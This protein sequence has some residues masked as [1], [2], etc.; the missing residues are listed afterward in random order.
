MF[1]KAKFMP[2]QGTIR[3][4]SSADQLQIDRLLRTSDYLYLRFTEQELPFLLARHPACGLFHGPSLIG[5]LL[6]QVLNPTTAWVSGFGVSW[7]EGKNWASILARL[8]DALGST[9]FTR[10]IDEL[11]YSGNDWE[12]DW[13]REPLIRQGWQQHRM[14]YAYDKF[15]YSIPTRGNTSVIVRPLNIAT[16]LPALQLLEEVCFEPLWR[17]DDLAFR[18]IAATH[19]YFVVAELNGQVI[20]YQFNTVDSGY[21]YLIRIA[22][23]PAVSGRGIGARLLAEAIR[24]FARERVSRIMLN[25]QQENAHAHR[26]Y[27]WFGFLRLE[28]MGFVLRWDYS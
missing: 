25:T 1:R 6:T 28:Q 9:L 19:P 24:F 8:R 10:G 13:L 14:L 2:A 23:H 18:D 4:L 26:L 12:G 20:G 21:G 11:Y 22:V 17:Y 15:D 7:T 3:L 16:D 5:F 27:E